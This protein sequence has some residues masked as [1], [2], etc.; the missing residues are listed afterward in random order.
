[1]LPWRMKKS[2]TQSLKQSL[3]ATFIVVIAALTATLATRHLAFLA[4]L[5]NVAADIRVA[6][7]QPPMPQSKEIAVI[8]IN[9]DTLSRFAYRSP[10]DRAFLASLLAQLDAK[11]AKAIGLDVLLDQPTE[12]AKDALLART[13]RQLK[14]PVFVSYTNTPGHVTEDQLDYL[15]Q[16]VPKE[17]RATANL[18]TDPFDGAVR[19]IFPGETGPEVPPSFSRKAVA[20]MGR[21]LPPARQPEI[22]WRVGPDADTPPFPIYPAHAVAALP[23]AWFEGRLLLI[24]ATLSLT[25]RHR[26]PMAI[27]YDDTRGMMPGILVQA[28]SISQLL[29]GRS[30]ERASGLQ[31]AGF[32]LLFAAIGVA[33]G[34][35]KRSIAFNFLMGMIVLTILWLGGVLGYAHGLPLVPLLAPSLALALS[36]WM[37]DTFIGKA[38]RKQKEFIQGAFSRYVSPAVVEQLVENPA[39]LSLTGRRQEASFLFT[40]IAGFTTLA[41]K[42]A[43]D[44]LSDLLNAYL[45]GAC[46]I[47]QKHQGTID[48][49]IGDAIMAVFNA[50]LPQADHKERAVRCALELDAYAEGFRIAQSAKGISL[51]VTRIGLHCGIAT[52]GNFGSQSRM[53]FTA[54]G[55]TVNTAA[56]TEGV[57]KY[58]GTRIC[59][60]QEIMQ[61]CPDL[62]FRLVGE[63]VLKGK[64]MPVMLYQPLGGSNGERELLSDYRAA[65]AELTAGAPRAVHAFERLRAKYPQDPL[66]DFYWR[67][68]QSGNLSTRIVMDEK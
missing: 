54:L 36:L 43:S 33:I 5:E 1:M 22:A 52:I 59:C 53:D 49:F 62:A 8:A 48:K 56:R 34:L 21:P 55:D 10:V 23:K 57:N 51:G 15:N 25:D 50:P 12:P 7:F 4:N 13:I 31:V 17:L 19:W 58:F 40:D 67:R 35:L 41:E 9:E 66:I 14:T 44:Q 61:G 27:L 37:M 65:Y 64:E 3:A 29:E 2:S 26:T 30:A 38:E 68:T 60:T 11:G 45:D 20:M 63:V 39:A 46:A 16:F 32:C 42:L 47:I 18:A 28:H 24:G 6:A